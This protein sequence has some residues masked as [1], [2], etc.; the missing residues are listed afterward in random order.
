MGLTKKRIAKLKQPGRYR[1][2][3]NLFLQVGPTGTKSWLFRYKIDGRERWMGLGSASDFSIEE[4]EDVAKTARD[5]LKKERLDPLEAR[6]AE[7]AAR[8][9]ERAAKALELARRMTFEE[10]AR[11]YFNAQESGWSNRKHRQ[12]FQNTLRDYVLPEIGECAVADIDTGLVLK[13]VEPHWNAKPVTMSRV[14]RRMGAVLDWA[15]VRG[16]RS[17]DNPARW[18][19]YL[20]KALPK[21]SEV[22]KAK[23]HAALPYAEIRTL[24]ASCE[25]NRASLLAR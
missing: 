7:R 4:A 11:Q 15:T 18:G 8:A 20:S 5:R 21:P 9:A 19:G 25:N 10:A 6:N 2:E 1:H 24:W 22:A 12:Q 14:L 3:R 16:Y 13:C 17:G 23:H